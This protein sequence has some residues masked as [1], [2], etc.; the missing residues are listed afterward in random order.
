MKLAGREGGSCGA[1]CIEHLLNSGVTQ[2]LGLLLPPDSSVGLLRTK[3]IET[4]AWVSRG[5]Y[6]YFNT[7]ADMSDWQIGTLAVPFLGKF[8]ICSAL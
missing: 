3:N 1:Q 6:V 2:L 5:K 4:D 7:P 8:T